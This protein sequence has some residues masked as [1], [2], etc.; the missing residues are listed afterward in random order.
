[1]RDRLSNFFFRKVRS[2]G[3]VLFWEATADV[4]SKTD[5]GGNNLWARNHG[6]GL[7]HRRITFIATWPA[8]SLRA[9][10]GFKRACYDSF[11]SSKRAVIKV[12]AFHVRPELK[13]FVQVQPLVI[14]E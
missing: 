12:Q 2:E 9:L 10:S 7:R 3:A 8:I 6:D 13:Y 14:D 5:G 11:Y 4:A 1:M